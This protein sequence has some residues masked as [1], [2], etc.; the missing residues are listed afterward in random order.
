MAVSL[1]APY[2]GA[3]IEIRLLMPCWAGRCVA[4]Y[5]GAWI[6]IVI[7]VMVVH[8]LHVAPYTGAWIEI[9]PS[10]YLFVSL[11]GRSLHGSVD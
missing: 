2:T 6:E 11:A 7:S 10:W 1:V 9:S 8:F 5:T 4:P 3:W